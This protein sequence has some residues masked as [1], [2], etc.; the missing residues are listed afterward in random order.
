MSAAEEGIWGWA[1]LDGG[2]AS[3]HR[4]ARSFDGGKVEEERKREKREKGLMSVEVI[5]GPDC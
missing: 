4:P 1:S 3:A 5:E 2:V